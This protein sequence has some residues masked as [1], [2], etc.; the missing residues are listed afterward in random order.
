[1]KTYLIWRYQLPDKSAGTPWILTRYQVKARSE[2]EAESRTKRK[3]AGCGFHSMSLV[4]VE[5]GINPNELKK[6]S[7]SVAC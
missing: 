7:E 2:K 6:I 3:F 4:A 5:Q 1:M